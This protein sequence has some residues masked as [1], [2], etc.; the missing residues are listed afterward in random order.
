MVNPAL[1]AFER[2]W[3]HEV[4]NS[5]AAKRARATVYTTVATASYIVYLHN[6]VYIA[7][8]SLCSVVSI[9][10]NSIATRTC[11]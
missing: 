1:S 3:L 9:S 8:S 7:S 6:Y 4:S 2:V 11:A 10:S 5:P